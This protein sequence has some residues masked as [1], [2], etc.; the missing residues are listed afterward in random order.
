MKN[1]ITFSLYYHSI[2]LIIM[3]LWCIY[4]VANGKVSFFLMDK[5]YFIVC[6]YTI[7]SLSVYLL[8]YNVGCSHI[9]A[10]ATV[11]MDAYHFFKLLQFFLINTQ[12]KIGVLLLDDIELLFAVFLRN[13]HTVFHS[14]CTNSHSHQQCTRAPF[15]PHPCQHLLFVD[16]LMIVSLIDMR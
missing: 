12:K 13:F 2:L 9:L 6:V 11:N 10:N 15:S 3:P 8:V 14:G 1:H 7:T 4:I 5:S 16:L